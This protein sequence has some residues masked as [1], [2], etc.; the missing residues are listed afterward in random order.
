MKIIRVFTGDD[1]ESHFEDMALP[2]RRTMSSATW[3]ASGWLVAAIAVGAITSERVAKF[4]PVT[5]SPA[6]TAEMTKSKTTVLTR[7][8]FIS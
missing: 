2:P 1:G 8:R 4:R 3:V 5:R 7:I 6:S